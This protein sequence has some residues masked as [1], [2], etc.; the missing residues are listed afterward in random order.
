MSGDGYYRARRISP[1][2]IRSA[3]FSRTTFGRRGIS[4]DEV[5][6]FLHR[7]AGDVNG[8]EDELAMARAENARLKDALRQ[9][10]SQQRDPHAPHAQPTTEV[11][12]EAITILSRAQRQIDAQV[13]EAEHYCRLREREARQRYDEIVLRAKQHAKEEA[14]RVARAY[15]VTAGG[16]YSSDGERA[17]RSAV[18]VNALLRSLDALAAHVDATRRA[19]AVEVEKLSTPTD[20]AWGTGD[21]ALTHATVRAQASY[22]PGP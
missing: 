12:P 11:S 7:V 5:L 10:Q 2:Q 21:P 20:A 22:R 6:R 15:R 4:E 17:E 3:T 1:E 18:W 14:E 19:F 13:A 9:W 8:I 16:G